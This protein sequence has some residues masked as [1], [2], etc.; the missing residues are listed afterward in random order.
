MR[1][2]DTVAQQITLDHSHEA[3]LVAE[4]AVDRIRDK[5]GAG[6]IGPTAV[7]RAAC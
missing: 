7:Y 4:A 3:R 6:V 5:F 1:D 2:A